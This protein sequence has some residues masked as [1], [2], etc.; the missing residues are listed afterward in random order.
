MRWRDKINDWTNFNILKY[1]KNIES[2]F[3]FETSFCNKDMDNEYEEIFIENNSLNNM[4]QDYTNFLEYI[5]SSKNKYV[6][7]FPNLSGDSILI[8]PIPRKNKDFTTIKDFIDNSSI[9]HQKFFWKKV[10]KE[11]NKILINNEKIYV[12]THGLGIPY[13]HL[14]LDK[15]PKYYIT[16][17]FI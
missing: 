8:I 5:K 3:F 10:A 7:S 1:P 9:T 13:F 17:N 2:R 4:Y 16:K 6:V 12:S 11:I 14:R 15:Y